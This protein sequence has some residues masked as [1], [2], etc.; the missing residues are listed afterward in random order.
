MTSLSERALGLSGRM[1]SGETRLRDLQEVAL[2]LV[3]GS[4]VRGQMHRTPGTRTLDYLNHQA[5]TFVAMTDALVTEPDGSVN[6]VSFVAVNK[7]HIVRAI[8]AIDVD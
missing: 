8:E 5:E 2:L 4:Q 7:A 6:R 3:D 1:S